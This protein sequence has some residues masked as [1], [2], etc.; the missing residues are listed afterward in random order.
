LGE[1]ANNIL[2]FVLVSFFAFK[3]DESG[4]ESDLGTVIIRQ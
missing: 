4:Y 2:F 3:A 1:A